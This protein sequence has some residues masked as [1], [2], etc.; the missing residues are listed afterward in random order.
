MRKLN[1]TNEDIFKFTEM[2]RKVNFFSQM[3]VGQLEKIYSFV[4]LFEYRKGDKICKQGD[5]GDAFYIVNTGLLGVSV[6]TGFF[7]S[8]RVAGLKPGDFFGEMALLDGSPRTATVA[9]E[10]DSTVFVLLAEHFNEVAQS[11][12]E[13]TAY[14][15]SLAAAR[16]FE[17]NHKQ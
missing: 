3:T 13:F 1:A 12:P 7:S 16:K 10:E 8:K 9:A 6:K 15:K 5:A 14:M 2:A 17:Q 11:S 4:M